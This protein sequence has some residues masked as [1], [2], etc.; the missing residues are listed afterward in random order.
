MTCS[1]FIHST[2]RKVHFSYCF[3][4]TRMPTSSQNKKVKVSKL[5]NKGTDSK[6]FRYVGHLSQLLNSAVIWQKYP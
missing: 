5:F 2:V 1:T 3:Y 6:Y 4:A